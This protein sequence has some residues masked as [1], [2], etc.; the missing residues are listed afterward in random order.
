M[1]GT[2]DIALRDIDRARFLPL[3]RPRLASSVPPGNSLLFPSRERG[4]TPPGDTQRLSSRGEANG[5][6]VKR[7]SRDG[8]RGAE[9]NRSETGKRSAGE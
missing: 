3:F 1:P 8:P 9:R 6:E 5:R 7:Y 2:R 4:G